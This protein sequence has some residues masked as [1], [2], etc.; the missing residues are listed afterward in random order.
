[1]QKRHAKKLHNRDQVEVKVDGEWSN[2]Y[3]IGSVREISNMIV[4]NVQSEKHGYI[5][6]CHLDIR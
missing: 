2:G 6:V 3:V 1:M 4:L 5:E